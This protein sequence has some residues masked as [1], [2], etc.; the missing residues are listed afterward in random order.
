MTDRDYESLLPRVLVALYPEEE[1]AR[2]DA[3]LTQ[4]LLTN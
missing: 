4:V 3:W 2:Y 1:Q